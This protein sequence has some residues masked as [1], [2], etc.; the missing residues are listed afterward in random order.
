MKLQACKE[1]GW[2]LDLGHGEVDLRFCLAV[3]LF[4]DIL[5][6]WVWQRTLGHRPLPFVWTWFYKYT[7]LPHHTYACDPVAQWGTFAIPKFNR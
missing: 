5:G 4:E 1:H 2:A 7:T 6:I 3:K